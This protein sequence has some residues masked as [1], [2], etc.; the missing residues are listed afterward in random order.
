MLP[1]IKEFFISNKENDF[2]L[3]N[4]QPY[5][6][7]FITMKKATIGLVCLAQGMKGLGIPSKFYS[8]ISYGKPILFIGSKNSEID[9]VIQ[10]YQI[11][12]SIDVESP[13]EEIIK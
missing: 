3:L 8:L 13:N 5:D 9:L 12:W 2:E 1:Y 6:Q 4:W 10:E 11:G 7:L